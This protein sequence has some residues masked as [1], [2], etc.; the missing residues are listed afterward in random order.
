MAIVFLLIYEP[1]YKAAQSI[2]KS[3]LLIVAH[4]GF[5]NY[6]PDNSLS[7]VKMA[8]EANVDGVDLDGQMTSDGK[9]VIYPVSYTHLRAHET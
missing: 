1:N 6:G 9:L 2:P 7:A 5:C 8:I 4:R 3:N